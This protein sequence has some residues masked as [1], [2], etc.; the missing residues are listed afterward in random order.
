MFNPESPFHQLLPNSPAPGNLLPAEYFDSLLNAYGVGMD[1]RQMADARWQTQARGG[2]FLQDGGLDMLAVETPGRG[3]MSAFQ[4]QGHHFG[5]PSSN[6]PVD[7]YGALH[8]FAASL[9]TSQGGGLNMPVQTPRQLAGAEP[10]PYGASFAPP[11][12]MDMSYGSGAQFTEPEGASQSRGGNPPEQGFNSRVLTSA[13]CITAMIQKLRS[14]EDGVKREAMQAIRMWAGS[15]LLHQRA[16]AAAGAIPPLVDVLRSPS[17]T[18]VSCFFCTVGKMLGA[19]VW[20]M[21]G[22]LWFGW[23]VLGLIWIYVAGA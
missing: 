5:L 9:V 20:R 18:I 12:E 16:V 2:A 23:R 1:P 17:S 19:S 7:M 11:P 4:M 8:R 10:S 21:L 22:M 15:S 3:D 6:S 14:T 13:A